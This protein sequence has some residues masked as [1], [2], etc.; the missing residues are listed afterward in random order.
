[1]TREELLALINDLNVEIKRSTD[2][3]DTAAADAAASTLAR[4]VVQLKAFDAATP[5]PPAPV[6]EIGRTSSAIVDD[7]LIAEVR[8]VARAAG[9]AEF[10]IER[11]GTDVFAVDP[12]TPIGVT[13]ASTGQPLLH[14]QHEAG[15]RLGLDADLSLLDVIPVLPTD[16][17]SLT[18]NREVGFT[19]AAALIAARAT[20]GG[21]D[22]FPLYP[23]SSIDTDTVTNVNVKVGHAIRLGEDSV[24]DEPG[25]R[26]IYERRLPEGVRARIQEW[27]LSDNDHGSFLSLAKVG[28][29]RAQL[30]EYAIDGDTPSDVAL[31][32]LE[33][34][35]SAVTRSAIVTN[36]GATWVA[37]SH[38]GLELM[39]R[40][41][42]ASG[43]FV[44]NPFGANAVSTIHGL[45]VIKVKA[46]ESTID[47]ENPF[48]KIIVGTSS[49]E[50][51]LLRPLGG[52]NVGTSN[53]YNDDFLRDAFVAKAAQRT[54]TQVFR[55]EAYVVVAPAGLYD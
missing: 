35:R 27:L 6:L 15:I 53:N 52:L 13:Y 25:L 54:I 46:L 18:Y 23:M 1:M 19:N 48:G 39:E 41:K 37:I 40:A 55:P 10:D 45:R 36:S 24:N 44:G 49:D 3:G 50:G 9:D 4:T 20:V 43:Y 17:T 14:T 8:R 33:A 16:A 26:R 38:T 51:M 30:V 2:A 7:E 47:A 29:G 42:H 22:D 21:V 11:A 31:A 32:A 5:N 12:S 34:V 28:A